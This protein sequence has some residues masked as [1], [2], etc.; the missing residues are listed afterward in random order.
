MPAN[1]AK[2]LADHNG[3]A[4][5]VIENLEP[6]I[7]AG[8]FPAKRVVGDNVVVE[9]DVFADGHDA[10]AV[11]L[12]FCFSGDNAWQSV[13]M[14]SVVNDRWTASFRVDRLGI[15]QYKV[16]GWVDHFATW[17]RDLLKRV[18]AGQDVA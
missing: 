18:D 6:R 16:A 5:V 4:R 13:A 1:L 15:Y 11:R 8:R 10:I 3:R 14:Q 9:A 7:D 17:R 12:D 2:P